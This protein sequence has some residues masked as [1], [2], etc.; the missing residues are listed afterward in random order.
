MK[1]FEDI[2]GVKE[3]IIKAESYLLSKQEKDFGFGNSFSTAWVMQTLSK[4]KQI[5]KGQQ[6]LASRQG[7]D[8][9]MDQS[10]SD[11]NTRVWATAYTIPAILHK[12]WGEILNKFP[13]Q[14]ITINKVQTR[15]TVIKKYVNP[16]IKGKLTNQ[17]ATISPEIPEIEPVKKVGF[18]KKIINFLFGLK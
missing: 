18:F 9:G 15:N 10:S 11:S 6:Y 8:G 16:N 17:E 12:S 4:N 2:L 14:E 5:F 3:S 13:K 1:G 7:T